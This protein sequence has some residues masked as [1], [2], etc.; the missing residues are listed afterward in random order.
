VKDPIY[1]DVYATHPSPRAHTATKGS[2]AG[3]ATPRSLPS[4][5]AATATATATTRA[6]NSNNR[7]GGRGGP[8]TVV[9]ATESDRRGGVPR[10]TGVVAFGWSREG[11][12]VVSGGGRELLVWEPYTLEVGGYMAAHLLIRR[13]SLARQLTNI[14]LL[15]V[16]SGTH[17]SD[18]AT[19][20]SKALSPPLPVV[21]CLY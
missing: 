12:Y 17:R 6:G 10:V 4:A 15:R 2:T 16:R 18:F 8:G 21:I 5:P 13:S 19:T 1:T 11:K 20:G 3:D 7:S 14:S 9:V